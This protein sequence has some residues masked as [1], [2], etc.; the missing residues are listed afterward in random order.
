MLGL[1][2]GCMIF[3]PQPAFHSVQHPV[4]QP[5]PATRVMHKSAGEKHIA[6]RRESHPHRVVHA[7]VQHCLPA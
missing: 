6:Q 7:A 1:T 3:A 4:T 5:D 2:D